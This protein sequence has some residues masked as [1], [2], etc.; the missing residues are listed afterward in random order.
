MST[1]QEDWSVTAIN[2]ANSDS[3][4]TLVEGM[5]PGLVNDAIRQVMARVKEVVLDISGVV[6]SGGTASVM[7]AT[8]NSSITTLFD[9]LIFAVRHGT[10]NTGATT[11]NPNALGGKAVKIFDGTSGEI[12]PKA[13]QIRLGN[14]GIYAYSSIANSGNGALILLNPAS[15]GS[16]IALY[17]HTVSYTSTTTMTTGAWT[18]APLSTEEY[19]PSGMASLA[20]NVLTTAKACSVEWD[21]YG[22]ITAG[23][24]ANSFIVSRLYNVTNSAVVGLIG[25]KIGLGTGTTQTVQISG[26]SKGE[27]IVE[28]G[29]QYR[30]EYYVYLQDGGVAFFNGWGAISAPDLGASLSLR[31]KLT[32]V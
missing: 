11:M 2:N 17:N 5:N 3:G 24:V 25:T 18:T 10:T 20:S 14:I 31:V 28:A 23:N 13:G 30:V 21:F 27:A 8:L 6:V 1:V 15:A 12:D 32:G 26:V 16:S 4:I 29:K 22:S 9:G 7:T 19:D